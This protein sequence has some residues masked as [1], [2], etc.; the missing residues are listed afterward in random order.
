MNTEIGAPIAAAILVFLFFFFVFR[1]SSFLSPR[2][3]KEVPRENYNGNRPA[4]CFDCA[5]LKEHCYGLSQSQPAVVS[6]SH[7][8][9]MGHFQFNGWDT[10][11]CTWSYMFS[12]AYHCS[13]FHPP[14][15]LQD[16]LG[17]AQE[18]TRQSAL[19]PMS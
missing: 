11:E 12:R 6:F 8:C 1:K 4:T 10:D 15:V 16:D 18:E 17:V 13:D 7:V 14:V 5:Y 9:S 19:K 2:Q 3:P